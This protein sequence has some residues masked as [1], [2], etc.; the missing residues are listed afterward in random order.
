MKKERKKKSKIH[1]S[2]N[3]SCPNISLNAFF[4]HFTRSWT[5]RGERSQDESERTKNHSHT[6]HG[7]TKARKWKVKSVIFNRIKRN[8]HGKYVYGKSKARKDLDEWTNTDKD[9]CGLYEQNRNITAWAFFFCFLCFFW[10]FTAFNWTNFVDDGHSLWDFYTQCSS[11][12]TSN[13]KFFCIFSFASLGN[14]SHSL[15]PTRCGCW[16]G[17]I[18]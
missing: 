18:C 8:V 10:F 11:N 9:C 14:F 16:V 12:A 7:P 13:Q 1:F 17:V 2:V 3:L 4:T 5:S 6:T 15:W